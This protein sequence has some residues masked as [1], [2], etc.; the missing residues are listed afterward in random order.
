MSSR[1]ELQRSVVIYDF[2]I[3]VRWMFL[4]WSCARVL[5]SFTLRN[6][7]ISTANRQKQNPMY[8]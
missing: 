2:F 6:R 8:R 5:F 4:S 1:S 3:R 7:R